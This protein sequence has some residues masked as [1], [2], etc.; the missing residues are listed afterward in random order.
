MRACHY[1]LTS[2]DVP[3]KAPLNVFNQSFQTTTIFTCNLS[4]SMNS[5]DNNIKQE[6][7]AYFKLVFVLFFCDNNVASFNHACPPY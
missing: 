7:H 5:N 3:L 2:R 4:V 1:S 6:E